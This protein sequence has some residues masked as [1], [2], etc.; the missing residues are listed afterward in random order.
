MRKKRILF[1]SEATFL[2]TGYATYAR[3]ILNYLHNTGKYELAELAS[4]GERNDRR[5]VGIP[6]RY[7]G[8]MPNMESEPKAAQSEIDSYGSIPTNQFGEFLFEHVCLD[9]FPDIVCDI[10]DF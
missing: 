4:Y 2:N 5:A 1:C 7:Y 6:W 10:R 8:V 3:E 9:F